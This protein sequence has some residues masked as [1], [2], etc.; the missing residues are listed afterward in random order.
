MYTSNEKEMREVLETLL[1]YSPLPVA[2]EMERK[3][4]NA[5]E[6]RFVA[7]EDFYLNEENTYLRL[8]EEYEKYKLIVAFDFDNT[9]F[10]YNKRGLLYTNVVALLRVCKEAGCYLNVLTSGGSENTPQIEA[11]LKAHN[12][13]YDGING[14]SDF[15]KFDGRKI[16]YNILLDDRAG[17]PSAYRILTRVVYHARSINQKKGMADVA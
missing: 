8:K 11:Y 16:N 6:D 3:I 1:K 15:I 12:I 9:V 17:L 10:N 4:R 5:L 14:N 7:G 13:P 2:K